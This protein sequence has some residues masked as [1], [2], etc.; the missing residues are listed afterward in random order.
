MAKDK[1]A[2]GHR[3]AKKDTKK[4]NKNKKEPQIP[5]KADDEGKDIIRQSHL[6]PSDTPD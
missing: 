3:D 2:H 6:I 4:N 5:P 1:S